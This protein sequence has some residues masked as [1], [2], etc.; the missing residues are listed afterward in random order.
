MCRT[1][2]LND[3]RLWWKQRRPTFLFPATLGISPGHFVQSCNK[4]ASSTSFTITQKIGKSF[5]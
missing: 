4:T 3:G 2:R 1:I 5:F